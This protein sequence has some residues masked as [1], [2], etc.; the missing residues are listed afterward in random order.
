LTVPEEIYYLSA[1][2]NVM[3]QNL[4]LEKTQWGEP[5]LQLL[6]NLKPFSEPTVMVIRHSERA[7]ISTPD[8]IDSMGLTQLG[9]EVAESFGR[10]LPS[11]KYRLFIS[12]N[13]RCRDTA[14]K[15]REGVMAV[16]GDARIMG[17]EESVSGPIMDKGKAY[18]YMISDW[19]SFGNNWLSG[20]YPPWEIEASLD[21]AQRVASVIVR[22]LGE[23]EPNSV[24]IYV[25]HDF[26]VFATMFHWFG[27]HRGIDT[28]GYLDGFA[29]QLNRDNMSV[30]H[31]DGSAKVKYPYWW[32]F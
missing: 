31:R 4:S 22:N 8:E 25:S 20:R 26:V 29:S 7:K 5:V 11:C 9:R 32:K 3:T 23:A 16:G 28:F 27:L 13:S 10:R 17:V 30:T 14:E 2:N 15:I 19:P 24:D 1:L 6:S 18:R 12:R 21:Y